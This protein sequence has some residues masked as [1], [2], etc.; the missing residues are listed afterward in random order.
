MNTP[1]IVRIDALKQIVVPYKVLLLACTTKILTLV[2]A[3]VHQDVNA[4]YPT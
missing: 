1:S 4:N 3:D 2:Q